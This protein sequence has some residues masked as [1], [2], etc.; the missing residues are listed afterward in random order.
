[1]P[2][3]PVAPPVAIPGASGFDYVT[4]DVTRRRVYAAHTGARALLIVN[5]DTGE[6]KGQVPVGPMHGVAVDPI[7]GVVF[8]GNGTD[9]TVSEVD[10]QTQK[11]VNSVSVPGA[12]DAIAYDVAFKR[13]YADEAN[14][15]RIFVID[16]RTMR[17]IATVSLPGHKPEY[18][19]IDPETHDVYQNIDDL[20]EV[21]V[22]DPRSLKVRDIITTPGI[23]HNHP[24]Q[25]DV[26]YHQIVTGG[27]GVLAA[28]ER[29]GKQLGIAA[30]PQVDQCALDQRTHYI[31]CAGGGYI[32]VLQTRPGQGPSV[33][34][35]VDV[36]N[37]VHTLAIDP[38]SGNVFAV[39][40]SPAGAF[41]QRFALH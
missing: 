22:V 18:L 28:Y 40:G 41:V 39:W 20:S 15:T 13:I 16:A 29:N 17:H 6:V 9:D 27:G 24:L 12:V 19:A 36:P 3:V 38:K 32:T 37:G 26:V 35:D 8:T 4:V 7:S 25:Y 23:A 30:I 11:V 14:G 34:A 21:A 10:P 1:M 33:I 31:A 2:L 5:A